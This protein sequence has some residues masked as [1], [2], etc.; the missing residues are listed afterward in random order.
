[1]RLLNV[2]CGATRPGE[3]WTNLDQLHD[4]L[5]PGTPERTNLDLEKNYVN[6]DI[7]LS[8]PFEEETFDGVLCS[9]VLEHFDCQDAVRIITRCRRVLKP[10]GI[11]VA[12]VPDASYFLEVHDEDTR[13]KAIDLFGEP[14]CPEEPEHKSFFDYALFYWQHKQILTLDSMLC[15]LMKAGFTNIETVP[16]NS[17]KEIVKTIESIMN[18]RKFSL[19]M[20]AFK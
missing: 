6:W 12:S 7:A 19:E 2:G 15:L 5:K 18:R 13:E 11:F 17:Q 8:L 10:E 20:M 3:P 16:S 4:V 9:H 14:I 1:M